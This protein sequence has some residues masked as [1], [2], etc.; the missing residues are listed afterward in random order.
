MRLL[1]IVFVVAWLWPMAV[2]ADC[3]WVLWT[4]TVVISE[5]DKSGKEV[6]VSSIPSWE[7]SN[8]FDTL[9]ECRQEVTTSVRGYASS[10]AKAKSDAPPPVPIISE[11]TS[12]VR[13]V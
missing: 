13:L 4:R 12:R 1:P 9:S 10:E 6:G 2:I 8:G 7:A 3:G 5:E 11:T